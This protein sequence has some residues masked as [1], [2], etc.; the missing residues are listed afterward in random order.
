MSNR[1]QILRELDAM[2]EQDLEKLL[3][4]LRSLREAHADAAMPR[5][6]AES[7][8]RRDWLTPEEDAAWADL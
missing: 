5:L 4:Y 8:L 7:A 1:E 2:P 3:T 6:A